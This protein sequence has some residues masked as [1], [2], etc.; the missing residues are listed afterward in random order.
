MS[1]L[2]WR[3]AGLRLAAALRPLG[4][5]LLAA[6]LGLAV[7]ALI[8]FALGYDAWAAYHALFI[9]AFSGMRQFA[10]S[11]S[12]AS[13]LIFT[14]LTFAIC[15]RAGKFNIGAEGQLFM[16]AMAAIAASLFYL[17]AG[18]HLV[19]ALLFGA[20]G[21]VM[22]ALVPAMLRAF[23]GVHEV[24]STIMFNWIGTFLAYYVTANLL[25]SPV[26]GEMTIRVAETSRFPL[27]MRGTE[28][29]YAIFVA[30]G[31]A[32]LVWL[33]LWRT[34]IGYEVRAAGANPNAG[35]YAGVAEWKMVLTVFVL[36]GVS[37]GLA[38]ATEVMGRPPLY[39]LDTGLSI[40]RGFG[41]DGIGVAMIGHN[42]P[43]GIILAAVFYGG[44]QS[45]ARMMQMMAGVPFQIVRV[46][47]GVII[48]ALALPELVRVFR[49]LR[50]RFG[51][52]FHRRAG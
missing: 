47:Q 40:V 7:G 12:N 2:S 24:I 13:P 1:G 3:M 4:N 39:A 26:R 33:I 38:G 25:V 27:L 45:G 9:G 14:A 15:F 52:L 28:L 11:L 30:L 49:V 31:F 23:R 36:G 10:G 29:S 17:P 51:F 41:F 21:G 8:M 6:L 35:R 18:L 48:I 34:V 20:A 32:V 50:G 37:A 16:G 43:L 22:W 42:H 19:M 5:S 44:L 46:V